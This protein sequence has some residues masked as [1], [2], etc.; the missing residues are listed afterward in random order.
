MKKKIILASQSPRRKELLEKAGFEFTAVSLDADESYPDNLPAK[1]VAEFLARKKAD[2]RGAVQPDEIIVTSD[3]VVLANGRILGKPEN[4]TEAYEMLA[5]MS[6]KS[7]EVVSGVCLKTND[8]VTSF[9]A[10]TRVF[11]KKL[12]DEEIN[13]Y[14]DTYRPYDKAGAYGIQ[15]WIGMIGIEKIEGSFYNV[16]GLPVDRVYTE[17]KKLL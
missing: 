10:S 16:M 12:T 2:A 8:A 3:T 11:F 7:H 15:E 14:I 17:L 5:S 6:G 4:K 13:Y 9:S 1:E